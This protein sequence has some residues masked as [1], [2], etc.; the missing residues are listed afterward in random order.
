MFVLCMLFGFKVVGVGGA[1]SST[2]FRGMVVF[3]FFHKWHTTNGL[4]F[5]HPSLTRTWCHHMDKG[6]ARHM[7]TC[8]Q[9]TPPVCAVALRFYGAPQWDM[10]SRGGC[11]A[12]KCVRAV[13]VVVGCL[14]SLCIGLWSQ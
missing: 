4:W 13:H 12:V 1:H 2:A 10:C 11:V 3:F 9:N 8:G 5:V 6:V 14:R 7:C